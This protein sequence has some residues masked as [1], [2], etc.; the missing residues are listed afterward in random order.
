MVRVFLVIFILNSIAV[1]A[2]YNDLLPIFD[3]PINGICK[4]P[5]KPAEFKGGEKELFS[6]I[7]KNLSTSKIPTKQKVEGIVSISF[8]IYR[9]GTICNVKIIKGINEALD[10]ACILVLSKMPKWSP[11]IKKYEMVNSEVTVPFVFRFD[12]EEEE[13]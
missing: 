8:V 6:Y 1:K 3:I 11:A 5:D 4:S 2:Q 10:K 9:D 13:E 12:K 7:S